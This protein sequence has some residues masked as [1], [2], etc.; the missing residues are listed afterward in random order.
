MSLDQHHLYAWG[1][2]EFGRLGR[3]GPPDIPTMIPSVHPVKLMA[4]ARTHNIVCTDRQVFTFGSGEFGKLGNGKLEAHTQEEPY[5][6]EQFTDKT[7]VEVSCGASHTLV[8]I[9]H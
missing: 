4:C 6:V 1:L 7:V 8:L 9:H 2:A 3:S 5:C